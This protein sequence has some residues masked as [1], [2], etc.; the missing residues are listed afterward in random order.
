MATFENTPAKNPAPV[1]SEPQVKPASHDSVN[2]KALLDFMLTDWKP[3]SKK[4]PKPIPFAKSFLARRRALSKQ[5]PGE[6]LIIPTGHEKVRANDTVYRFRPGT[7][8]YYLTGNMEPDCVLVM[9]P[10]GD[11]HKDVLFVEP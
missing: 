1:T 10:D 9:L 8:F 6:A 2:P 7:D 5:F 4:P 11:G 3:Q